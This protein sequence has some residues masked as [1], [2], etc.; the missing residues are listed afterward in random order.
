MKKSRV[1]K[2]SQTEL[3]RGR[4][5]FIKQ[6]GC[7]LLSSTVASEIIS[8]KPA[9]AAPLG[10][11][12]VNIGTFGPSHCATPFVY[13]K[14]C[15]FFKKEKLN[16]NLINYPTMPAIAKDLIRGKLDMCQ[17]VVPLVFAIHSGAS[18]FVKTP[19]VVTQITGTNG[20]ALMVKKGS[21]IA[22]PLDFK[23][24]IMAVH[25]KL[26]VNYLMN[27]MFLESYGLRC[28]QDVMFKIIDKKEIVSAMQNGEI[29]SFLM[30]EPQDAIT[31]AKDIGD[32]YLLSKYI[33]PNHPCCALA[34][35]RDFFEE[36]RA[37]VTDV[38][39]MVTKGGLLANRPAT[40]LEAIDLLQSSPD[41]N[42]DKVPKAVLREA[43]TPGRSD[44][45]PFPYQSSALL[46]IEIMKKYHLLPAETDNGK[47]AQEVFQSSL[48]RK[49]MTEL[50]ADAPV[51]DYR[52]EK[53]LGKLKLYTG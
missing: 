49:L 7:F 39:R 24:K 36:N 6:A 51:S 16:V 47:L 48:S 21:G 23:G 35:R 15:G 42:Y 30:P 9:L 52:V 32:I 53:I 33:W 28:R 41:Y 46:I 8:A 3:V 17:L 13:S 14:L 1:N 4:R 11:R 43:F 40:R 34:A 2:S 29:D 27:I 20:S 22:G 10:S 19:M 50:G 18:P 38:T 25:S 31:E 26:S 5:Q 37:M 12:Q 45:Y 44:F